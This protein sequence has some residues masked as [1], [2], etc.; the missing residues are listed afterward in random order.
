MPRKPNKLKRKSNCV[1]PK[2]E[3]QEENTNYIVRIIKHFIKQ[4]NGKAE[5]DK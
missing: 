3:K 5:S 2:K 4:K 1:A